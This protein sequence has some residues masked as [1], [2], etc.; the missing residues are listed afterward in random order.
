MRGLLA[1]CLV[2]VCAGQARAQSDANE[3]DAGALIATSAGALLAMGG[4]GA[5]GVMLATHGDLANRKVGAYTLLSGLALAPILSHALSGEWARAALFGAV[6]VAAA[7]GATLLIERTPVLLGHGTLPER[8]LFAASF[9]LAL[10]SSA[11]GVFDSL[12]V[13]ERARA[14]AHALAIAPVIT[15]G[16][17]GVV[18]GGSL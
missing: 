1:A 6:P 14:R 7:L 15:R 8:R 4:L 17:L 3:G 11:I 13:G 9:G 12:S 5:G 2:V 10:L 16:G 18:L